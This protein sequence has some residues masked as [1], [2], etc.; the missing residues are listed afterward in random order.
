MWSIS[1]TMNLSC[2]TVRVKQL[3]Y[4]LRGE[5]V[6]PNGEDITEEKIFFDLLANDPS[7]NE[8]AG[9]PS[10]EFSVTLSDKNAREKSGTTDTPPIETI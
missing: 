10:T 6:R 2:T 4:S 3:S 1:H 7:E 9:A 5:Y 8:T